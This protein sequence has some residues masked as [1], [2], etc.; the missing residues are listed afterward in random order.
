[1]R[2]VHWKI[3]GNR[4]GSAQKKICWKRWRMCGE[5]AVIYHPNAYSK[6]YVRKIRSKLKAEGKRRLNESCKMLR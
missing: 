2:C 3:C 1:M 6:T 5:C 4:T